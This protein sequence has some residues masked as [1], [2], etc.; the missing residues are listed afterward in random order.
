MPA[1]G[2]GYGNEMGFVTERL[3]AY[4]EERARGGAALIIVE[5][6]CVDSQ[7]GRRFWRHLGIDSDQFIPSL[8]ELTDSI[9]QFGAKIAL[10]LHHAGRLA[11]PT[12]NGG[13]QPVSASPIAGHSGISGK[14]IMARELSGEEVEALIEKFVQGVSRAQRAGF[15]AVEFHGAHGFLIAQFLSPFTNHRTDEYGK[16]LQGRMRFAL[17]IVRR[18]KEK[19]G[20]DFPLI[21]RVSAEEY[22]PGGLTLEE[23][24]VICRELE[25]VG[26]DALHVSAGDGDESPWIKSGIMPAAIAP[27][28]LVPFAEEIKKVVHVPVITVG[29]INDPR[30][31]EKILQDGKA[32]LVAMARALLVDP[33]LPQKAFKEQYEDI[34]KC[35]GCSICP[36]F[37]LQKGGVRCAVNPSLGREKEERCLPLPKRKKVLIAGGGPAGL[38][39]ARCAALRGHSVI[40]FEKE[41]QLGGQLNLAA[42]APHKIEMM[43]IIHYL[44]SQL[45]KLG[46]EVVVGK[47]VTVSSIQSVSPEVI[48]IAT[49]VVP[50]VLEIMGAS[51]E[52]QASTWEVL[53]GR[54]I[55]EN[56]VAILGSSSVSLEAAEV[57]ANDSK[58]VMVL[59]E[60]EEVG[61][62]M[63]SRSRFLLLQ[64][65]ENN[66]V[67]ILRNVHFKEWREN[68]TVFFTN[69]EGRAETVEANFIVFPVQ[70][71]PN[72]RLANELKVSGASKEIDVYVIGDCLEPRSLYA[73][74]HDGYRAG[75]EM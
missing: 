29:R 60:N 23:A 58:E 13:I 62:D 55:S 45:K 39:A 14:A 69:R 56:Q 4:L 50:S 9:H 61:L 15:D 5:C 24:K 54:K 32:D 33:Y 64:R 38:E 68:K 53:G 10:Q 46:V 73:A 51:P 8:Y 2:T 16:D 7:G 27:G 65:L 19:V 72:Q 31:A 42:K 36:T 70:P 48:V 47:E 35:I 59:A 71:L 66:K 57:L 17:E 26:V 52:K 22:L 3:K 49:G 1:M 74:I 25:K 21:F 34:R 67:K 41:K 11:D 37:V 20:Q 6:T 12:V 18:S 44:S 63:E 30:L 75:L 28:C 40:L 43:N